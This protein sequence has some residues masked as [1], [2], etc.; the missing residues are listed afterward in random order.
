MGPD[1]LRIVG[2]VSAVGFLRPSAVGCNLKTDILRSMLNLIL[3]TEAA[4]EA[5]PGDGLA[6]L[7]YIL[8]GVTL[9]VAAITTAIV[10]PKAESHH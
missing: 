9:L 5:P 3:A 2:T 1:I 10:T 4:T 8:L 6:T 7:A